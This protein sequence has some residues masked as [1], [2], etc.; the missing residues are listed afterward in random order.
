MTN[1]QSG[2]RKA[3]VATGALSFWLQLGHLAVVPGPKKPIEVE[4]T[5]HTRAA[6][7]LVDTSA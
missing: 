7:G 1:L 5:L 3:F 4:L 2:Q 6:L